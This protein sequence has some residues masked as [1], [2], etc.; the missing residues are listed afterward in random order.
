M[1]DGAAPRRIIPALGHITDG[2]E[3]FAPLLL[4]LTVG[5]ALMPHGAQKLF[6]AFGGYGLEGTGQFL[7]TQGF[8]PGYVFALLIGLL[9]FVG[10][11][12]LAIG[13]L[14]RPL[15]AAVTVFMAVAITVHYPVYFWNTAGF[16]MPMIWGM[17]ALYFFLKGG[18]RYSVDR[19]IGLEF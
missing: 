6:G 16:E 2:L 10:G 8:M 18:G 15:A 1:T 19:K 5:L 12:F 7:E 11:F 3:S 17:A 14:T 9:E 13:F 4:R